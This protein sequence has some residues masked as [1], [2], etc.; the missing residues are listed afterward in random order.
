MLSVT[1]NVDGILTANDSEALGVARYLDHQSINIP[2]D[3]KVISLAGSTVSDLFPAR[4]SATV[5]PIDEISLHALSLIISK[6][7]KLDRDS[8]LQHLQINTRYVSQ[9]T[10]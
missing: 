7:E 8:P 4:V 10:C 9:M 2:N 1:P 6:V 3:I 5:F